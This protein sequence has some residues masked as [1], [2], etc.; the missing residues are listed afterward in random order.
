MPVVIV[1]RVSVPVVRVAPPVVRSA[2]APVVRSAPSTPP[3]AAKATPAPEYQ[4]NTAV[5]VAAGVAAGVAIQSA[6]NS[7]AH[8]SEEENK[9]TRDGIQTIS[10]NG[11]AEI[12]SAEKAPLLPGQTVDL[13]K[14]TMLSDADVSPIKSGPTAAD[15]TIVGLLMVLICI[16]AYFT[17]PIKMRGHKLMIV[18]TLLGIAFTY[19]ISVWKAL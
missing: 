8:A 10:V 5:N 7:S 12:K 15:L 3:P 14:S 17:L 16:V 4:S 2:P 6:L 18:L 1:P 11:P 19:A 9:E 13:N